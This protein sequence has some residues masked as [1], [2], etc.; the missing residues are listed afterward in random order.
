MNDPLSCHF[1]IAGHYATHDR[2]TV[3]DFSS[4]IVFSAYTVAIENPN[5]EISY[6]IFFT[7]FT[8]RVWVGIVIVTLL[9]TL[10]LS[11]SVTWP[12][13]HSKTPQERKEF[14]LAKCAIF[15]IG[16]VTFVR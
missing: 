5:A 15:A 3:V 16:G 1:S 2:R 14:T 4:A 7:P 12:T 8:V 6:H 13:S 10:L 11:K 9:S